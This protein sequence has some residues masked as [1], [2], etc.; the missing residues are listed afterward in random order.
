M[1]HEESNSKELLLNKV[2]L[3]TMFFWLIKIMA[4][5]VGETAADLLNFNLKLG[6][7]T[8]SLFMTALLAVFL[9]MQVKQKK[10]IPWIYWINVLFISVAG[11][12]I[13]DNLVDNLGVPLEVTTLCFSLL[14]ALVFYVWYQSEKTLSIL[15]INTR[16]RE[17][18]YWL[19]ILLTFALGTSAGD[20][21]AESFKLGY[22]I[23]A[24]IFALFIAV[25]VVLKLKFKLSSILSFWT[26]YILTRPLGASF[27]DYL[28]QPL[29]YGGL[30]LGMVKTS[31]VFLAAMIMIVAYLTVSKK[32]TDFNQ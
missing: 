18:Y 14:L 16:K 3:V 31:V 12:L 19:T 23:S 25:V 8:T 7:I 9:V 20:L 2:P 24:T 4:T 22:L 26:A 15:S 30:G 21:F 10:Y 11:T 6:L 28:A 13:T 29:S 1:I 32:D 5:T 17:I 27:A